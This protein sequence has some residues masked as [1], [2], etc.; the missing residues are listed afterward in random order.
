ML[1]LLRKI[2]IIEALDYAI[3]ILGTLSMCAMGRVLLA[4][5]EIWPS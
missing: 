1:K 2:D 3:Y 4:M 5:L